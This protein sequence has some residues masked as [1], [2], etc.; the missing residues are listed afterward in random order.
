MAYARITAD[1][2]VYV[3]KHIRG[4]YECACPS[5][6]DA[7]ST[8]NAKKMLAHLSWHWNEDDKVPVNL[9]S[10]FGLLAEG[11]DVPHYDPV[12]VDMVETCRREKGGR[13]FT[14]DADVPEDLRIDEAGLKALVEE[15]GDAVDMSATPAVLAEVDMLLE[16]DLR[17]Q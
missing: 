14:W 2:D 1:C 5:R 4:G 17:G 9:L 13:I 8:L 7:L 10:T 11:L 3:F 16:R 15:K 6:E 12:V